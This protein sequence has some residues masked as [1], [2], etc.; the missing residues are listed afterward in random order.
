MKTRFKLVT[1]V[2]CII[3]ASC[4]LS[5]SCKVDSRPTGNSGK[6]YAQNIKTDIAW[7]VLEWNGQPYGYGSGF[8]INREEGTFY[9]NRQ[10]L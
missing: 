7:I 9:T 5:L 2:L 4:N 3:S 10:Y 8:L 6:T 1:L